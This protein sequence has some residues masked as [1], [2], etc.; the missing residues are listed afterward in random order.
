MESMWSRTGLP[1]LMHSEPLVFDRRDEVREKKLVA[2][3]TKGT[4]K[5]IVLTKFNGI[6]SPFPHVSTVMRLVDS[7]HGHAEVVSLD[8]VR[9]ERIY[10]LLGLLDVACGLVTIDTSI[11]H[12]A[13]G[14]KCPY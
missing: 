8:T 9:A 10:D 12:L 6:S 14:S 4:G 13:A 3:Y 11:L 7:L 1:E 5:P 2:Q